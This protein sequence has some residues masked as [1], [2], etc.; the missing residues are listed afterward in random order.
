MEHKHEYAYTVSEDGKYTASCTSCDYVIEIPDVIKML[1]DYQ[2]LQGT[3]FSMNK[4]MQMVLSDLVGKET[5]DWK[6]QD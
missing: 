6:M 3:M 1:W 2:A 4:R 5:Y